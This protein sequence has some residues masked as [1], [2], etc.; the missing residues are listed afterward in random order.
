MKFMDSQPGY[1]KEANNL[2][3][4]HGL[5]DQC[6]HVCCLSVCLS[7]CVHMCSCKLHFRAHTYLRM[8][9]PC[10]CVCFHE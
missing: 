6:A 4:E 3:I 10:A 2:Y 9:L 5:I 8:Y 1:E 7:V